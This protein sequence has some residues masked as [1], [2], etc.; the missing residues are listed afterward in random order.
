MGTKIR[1]EVSGKNPYW[2][3]KHRYYELLHFCLQYRSWQKQYAELD[4]YPTAS[5]SK[6]DVHGTE[7]ADPTE[8]IA[9]QKLYFRDRMEMVE[10]A[11]RDTDPVIGAYIFKAVTEGY[12][13]E[14]LRVKDRLPCCKNIYY[15]LYRKFFWLLDKARK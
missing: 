15:E 11:A 1:P 6:E 5:Y 8:R 7:I 12:S 14:H 13:Y 3:E 9:E 4:G 2:I 10:K